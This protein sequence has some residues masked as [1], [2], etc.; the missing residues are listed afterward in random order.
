MIVRVGAGDPVAAEDQPKLRDALLRLPADEES[1]RLAE[2]ADVLGVEEHRFLVEHMGLSLA[3]PFRWRG[4][5]VGGLLLGDKITGTQCTSEDV[6]LLSALAGPMAVSLQNALLVRDRVQVARLEE[7]MRLAREIQRSFLVHEFPQLPRFEIHAVNIP[8]KAVGGDLY[9]LV[10]LGDGGC[11]LAI[12]DVAGKGV[13]A[14]LLSSMLQAALRT[15]AL[16][17]P[18]VAEILR[19]INSLVYRGTALHQFATFFIARLDGAGRMTFSNAGHNYPVVLRRGG[20]ELLLER[21]GLVLGVREGVVY[22]EESIQLEPGDRLVL[23]TDGITEAADASQELF[24]EERLLAT[25]RD[26]PADLSAREVADRI[27]AELDGFLQGLEA[28]DDR[29]L[30]VM[31]VLEPASSRLSAGGRELVESADLN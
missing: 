24:G 7:E 5:T 1:V 14:A 25:L 9:D 10:P 13:P 23:Y 30:M 27:L 6:T 18:S 29:T 16:S 26:L 2:Q 17:V 11:L 3:V 22:E 8:S 28:L 21:G 12:A 20:G 15:Q 19:N 4:E 31:R